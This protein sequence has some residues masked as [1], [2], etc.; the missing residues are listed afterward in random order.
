VSH[1]REDGRHVRGSVCP[2]AEGDCLIYRW[3]AGGTAECSKQDKQ[4]EKTQIKVDERTRSGVEQK[5]ARACASEYER[6]REE[7]EGA[8]TVDKRARVRLHGVGC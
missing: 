4:E 1:L 7:L 3:A 2:R 8:D 6:F 5:G